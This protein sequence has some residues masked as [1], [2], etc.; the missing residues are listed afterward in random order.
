IHPDSKVAIQGTQTFT[1]TV[2]ATAQI[3]TKYDAEGDYIPKFEWAF[4]K[5][6][7]MP[8]LNIRAGRMGAPY[9]MISD[10]RDV[11]YANTPVRPNL[12]VY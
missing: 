8:G 12:D 11:G 9:F 7:A 10:F 4:A 6:Q 1:N 3:M 2:S 5:W